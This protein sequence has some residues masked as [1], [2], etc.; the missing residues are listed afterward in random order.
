[1]RS[2]AVLPNTPLGQGIYHIPFVVEA[3]EQYHCRAD[4]LHHH[5]GYFVLAPT[6]EARVNLE[7]YRCWTRDHDLPSEDQCM[8]PGLY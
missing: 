7:Q 1:M 5:F 6:I 8:G 4:L 2:T 3:K